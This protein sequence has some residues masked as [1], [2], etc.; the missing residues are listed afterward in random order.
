MKCKS[1]LSVLLPSICSFAVSLPVYSSPVQFGAN[2]YDFVGAEGINWQDAKNVAASSTFGNLNGSLTT[3]TSVAE[4]N[5]LMGQFAVF[6]GFS[7][8]WLGGEVNAS[9]TGIWMTGQETG[10]IF[11]QGGLRFP[12]LTQI[13][14]AL[15]L[16]A[17]FR[18]SR[19]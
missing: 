10:Q 6:S 4:N 5:F 9:G 17:R 14:E 12:V 8:A 2:F 7:G 11:S 18:A 15:S 3:I 19:I 13:G 16:M 1:V